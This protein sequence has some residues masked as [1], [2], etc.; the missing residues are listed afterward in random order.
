MTFDFRAGLIFLWVHY[1]IYLI[2][3]YKLINDL[4]FK[5][6]CICKE[7]LN[8][9]SFKSSFVIDFAHLQTLYICR[10]LLKGPPLPKKGTL[11]A[12]ES[13]DINAGNQGNPL[14]TY[15]LNFSSHNTERR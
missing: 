15:R 9:P 14:Y 4:N 13:Y 2:I 3:S 6:F 10:V 5:T 7:V 12:L 8:F 1:A 11:C